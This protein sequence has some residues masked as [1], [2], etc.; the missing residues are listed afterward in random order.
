MCISLLSRKL[1]DHLML[2]KLGYVSQGS[3]D[4]LA[5]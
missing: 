5:S 4:I 3:S 2:Q 1:D